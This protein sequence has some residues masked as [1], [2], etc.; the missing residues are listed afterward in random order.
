LKTEP[1]RTA[2]SRPSKILISGFNASFNGKPQ[3]TS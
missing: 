2:P 1:N 3:A